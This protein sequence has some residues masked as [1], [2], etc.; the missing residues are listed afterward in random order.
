MSCSLPNVFNYDTLKCQSCPAGQA[1]DLNIHS[2]HRI[3]K[4]LVSDIEK[5]SNW[6][7]IRPLIE[8]FNQFAANISHK[9]FTKCPA[10][11][12]YY[13]SITCIPCNPPKYFDLDKE[14]CLSVPSDKMFDGNM[15]QLLMK[16]SRAYNTIPGSKN[17]LIP[18][19]ELTPTA[20]NDLCTTDRPYYDGIAC[21][22][23]Q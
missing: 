11:A 8:I 5:R 19:A 15:H 9:N 3:E 23:C 2:C 18:R 16:D 10:E 12:S 6:V 22:Y 17:M 13:D 7:T 21:I 1:F 20:R 4:G 14:R